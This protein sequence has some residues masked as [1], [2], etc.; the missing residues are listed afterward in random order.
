MWGLMEALMPRRKWTL[1]GKEQT[2]YR[3]IAKRLRASGG[4]LNVDGFGRDKDKIQ[5]TQGPEILSGY[6]RSSLCRAVYVIQLSI[7]A[8]APKVILQDYQLSSSDWDLNAYILGDPSVNNS[9]CEYYRLPDHTTFHRADVLNHRIGPA[10]T[11]RRG[12]QMEGFLLA[13][14]L[15]PIPDCYKPGEVM[16]VTLAIADQ[17]GDEQSVKLDVYVERWTETHPVPSGRRGTLFA[18]GN[19]STW[20][21]RFH[22][23]SPIETAVHLA[24]R[25]ADNDSE[26][27]S[28]KQCDGG[29]TSTK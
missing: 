21:P 2:E 12:D 6:V 24:E 5:V 23:Q 15:Q 22:K 28:G 18:P 9:R 13:D 10:G 3:T 25:Q 1:S 11:L 20:L 29:A 16:Q 4:E 26:A 7:V 8:L 17:F 14:A 27:T 19:G